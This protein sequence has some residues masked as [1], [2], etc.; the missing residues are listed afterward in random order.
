M[1]IQFTVKNWKTFR[2][3]AKLTLFASGSDKKTREADNVFEVPKFG[4]R[5]LKSAVIYGANASGKTKLV[6]AAS[7][8]RQFIESSSKESQQG[9]PIEVD[10]FR[11]NSV[12]ETEPSSFEIIFIY[13]N[14]L[15]RYGFEANK[16]AITSEW[17]FHRP[18]TK[19]VEIFYRQGEELAVH[20]GFTKGVFLKKEKMIRPNTLLLSLAAQFNDE[21]A[22]KVLNWLKGFRLLSGL[23][24]NA[25]MGFSMSQASKAEYKSRFLEFLRHADIGI[26]DFEIQKLDGQN[27]PKTMPKELKRMIREEGAELFVD[28][29]TFHPKFDETGNQVGVAQFSFSD[30]ESSG[31]QKLFALMGPVFATLE[32]GGILFADELDSKLHP[33]LVQKLVALF[34]SAK[35]NFKNAQLVFNTHNTNLLG[36]NLF[37]RDQIW[38]SEKD[39]FGAASLFSLASFT[40]R[41]VK[42]GDDFETR[43]LEGRYGGVPILGDFDSMFQPEIEAR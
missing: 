16:A 35:A 38:F 40:T 2:D 7:F 24:E 41:D 30:D 23:D 21:L 9:E 26:S 27:L 37:R 10:S 13:D 36:S 6:E 29:K 42:K 17:L 4:L 20:S 31:T 39:R 11:L 15:F 34:N 28:A 3:E 1:L 25:Y 33:G 8:F 43:Y 19:E 22:T 5:L 18:N 14:E 32:T 12:T